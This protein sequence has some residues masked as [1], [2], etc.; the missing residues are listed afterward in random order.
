M[1]DIMYEPDALDI[2]HLCLNDIEQ[3]M[4]L[5]E[6]FAKDDIEMSFII[7]DEVDAVGSK[8][9]HDPDNPLFLRA[10]ERVDAQ[11]A[12]ILATINSR[13]SR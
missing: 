13:S 6:K 7:Y 10:I 11:I 9:G 2:G 4:L 1:T 8:T 12:R 3:T 5:E